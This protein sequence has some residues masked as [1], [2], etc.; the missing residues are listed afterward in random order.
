MSSAHRAEKAVGA[1]V[2]T[3]RL[4]RGRT[5]GLDFMVA[6]ARAMATR[7]SGLMADTG[8]RWTELG[9]RVDE[10]PALGDDDDIAGISGD[11]GACLGTVSC[12]KGL[13]IWFV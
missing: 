10:D 13:D 2:G 9:R 7:D 12:Q 5:G 6:L 1:M 8:C 4:R 11:D 3:A